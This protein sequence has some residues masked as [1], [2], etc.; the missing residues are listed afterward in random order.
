MY[1]PP[2]PEVQQYFGYS[3]IEYDEVF[4]YD[5]GYASAHLFNTL[6]YKLELNQY[7][8]LD[9]CPYKPSRH[10]RETTFE[11]ECHYLWERGFDD[12][13]E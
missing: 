11:D 13:S 8:R 7:K 6:P 5:E 12:Y 3:T 10:E 1:D 2:E 4:V 9:R